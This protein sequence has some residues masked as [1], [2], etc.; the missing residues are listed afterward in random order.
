M[1]TPDNRPLRAGS[2]R[3]NSTLLVILVLSAIAVV[4]LLALLI[5]GVLSPKP[6]PKLKPAPQE[7]A[8]AK[9]QEAAAAFNAGPA[10]PNDPEVKAVRE[11]IERLGSAF[12]SR[13]GSAIDRLFDVER[14]YQEI[15][16]N[17][18]MPTLS[19]REERGFIQ[20]LKQGLV[21]GLKNNADLMGFTSVDL[22]QCRFAA[23]RN[24]AIAFTRVTSD[25]GAQKFRW[26]LVKRGDQWLIYDFEELST[27]IRAC[28][29]IGGVMDAAGK[30]ASKALQFKQQAELINAMSRALIEGNVEQAEQHAAQIQT[31]VLSVPFQ[32]LVLMLNGTVQLHRGQ[33]EKALQLFD[34]AEQL[35]PD[36]VLLHF[37]RAVAHN[38]Q[39]KFEEARQAIE[40]YLNLLG[41]DADG[42][43]QLGIALR[44]LNRKDEAIA[45]FRKGLDDD[46]DSYDNLWQLA[47]LL[48]P[49]GKHEVGE[50]FGKMPHQADFF[51]TLYEQLRWQDEVSC[52]QIVDHYAKLAPNSP[53]VA[54]FRANEL[55]D[56]EKFE[57]AAQQA[58]AGHA[59]ADDSEKTSLRH[60][61]C[62]AMIRLD[63][64]GAAYQELGHSA[65]AFETLASWLSRLKKLDALA[66][67]I[68]SHRDRSPNDPWLHFYSG[69]VALHQQRTEEALQQLRSAIDIA[70]DDQ[71]RNRLR[72]LTVGELF[73]AGQSLAAYDQFEP[74]AAVFQQLA[75][76]AFVADQPDLLQQ[77]VDAER[78]RDPN[79]LELGYWE[80]ELAYLKKD[81]AATLGLAQRRREAVRGAED[82]NAYSVSNR[83]IRC[84]IHL[85]RFDEAEQ[86]VAKLKVE[87]NEP[88]WY[89]T[90]LSAGRGN[91]A[92]TEANIT[93]LV[94]QEY[95]PAEFYED[96]ILGPALRSEPFKAVREKYP[97]PMEAPKDQ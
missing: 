10:D 62:R 14:L 7:S 59:T 71:L 6:V 42:Y 67:L 90:L 74:K 24:E 57:A 49:E 8:E 85:Q 43:E 39:G 64:A 21:N 73:D 27:S 72:Y 37:T 81:Y 41:S 68:T 47:V 30:D 4:V 48:P 54:S 78:R 66:E 63:R 22:R 11:T 18:R 70:S 40:K 84:L 38:G 25:Q 17:S 16:R 31:D 61:Y 55:F 44:G 52:R 60:L 46:P 75:S 13:D 53:K 93:E 97:E 35:Q 29:S 45:A 95:E 26:W 28:A 82:E 89:N 65:E 88:T 51:D 91:V 96:D 77:L 76:R 56:Q 3:G 2:R 20:G 19:A 34:Q 12:V 33:F 23:D 92:Q 50:R 5:S 87:D 58:L 36:M 94:A 79:N 9:F 32:A 80:I 86:E 15:A 69:V 1:S 83:I